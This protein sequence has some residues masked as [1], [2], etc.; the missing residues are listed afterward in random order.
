LDI[1][2]DDVYGGYLKPLS[3]D[4]S[5][6]AEEDGILCADMAVVLTPNNGLLHIS[7]FILGCLSIFRSC[8]LDA[9][10]YLISISPPSLAHKFSWLSSLSS[11]G[12]FIS[13]ISN[14]IIYIF[15]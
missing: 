15:L 14:G 4:L 5:I 1:S 10:S 13:L 2:F 9:V 3:I 11:F 12:Q 6:S 8:F 7:I